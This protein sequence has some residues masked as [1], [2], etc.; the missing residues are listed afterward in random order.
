M[1]ILAVDD[2][3]I[4]LEAIAKILANQTDLQLETACSGREALE[5]AESFHPHLIMMDIKLPGVNGLETLAEIR[6]I[7][8]NVVTIIISAY[9]NFIYAQDAIR[10]NVFDYLLKPVNKTRLLEMIAR[11]GQHLETLRSA[12]QAE[13]AR[14]EQYKKLRPLLERELLQ[15]LQVASQPGLWEDYQAML[16]LKITAGFFMAL[17]FPK[18][19]T[20][21]TTPNEADELPLEKITA[22]A[23]WLRRRFEC[24]IGPLPHNPLIVFVPYEQADLKATDFT[25]L[26]TNLGNR[27]IEYIQAEPALANVRIGIGNVRLNPAQF[28]LSYQEALQALRQNGKGLL[29][30]NQTDRWRSNPTQENILKLE[31]HEITEAVRFG[32]TYRVETLMQKF[33][34]QYA[35]NAELEHEHLL[36]HLL[37]LLLTSYR[38]CQEVSPDQTD[39]PTLKQLLTILDTSNGLTATFALVTEKLLNL[40]NT[41][42]NNRATQVKTIIVKAKAVIDELYQQ[43]LSLEDVAHAVAVSPFYL[44]RLFREEMGIGFTEYLTRLRLEK[45]LTLLTQGQT[46]KECSFAIGYNDPNY[47]SRLFRKHF[48]LSPTEYRE[49]SL[50][51]KGVIAHEDSGD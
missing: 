32:Q 19:I 36:I 30:Y 29:Y 27:V 8:P 1:K 2:E 16:D 46:V 10:L 31:L 33:A 11:V 14:R 34:V 39:Y 42:K 45:S 15:T 48:Q 6:R 49:T 7:L 9:D 5:K 26:Q 12:H 40:T 37:E 38:F 3:R 4:M 13:I 35:E 28:R 41:I 21:L 23:E 20:P 43:D 44:S 24:L 51:K 50:A 25:A 47:F 22:L 17:Y 18:P